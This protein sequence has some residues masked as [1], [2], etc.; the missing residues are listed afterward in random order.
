MKDVKYTG[1]TIH[2]TAKMAKALGVN[3]A[4]DLL[5][6]M[7]GDTVSLIPIKKNNKNTIKCGSGTYKLGLKNESDV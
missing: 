3:N 6:V 5:I 1:F 7:Y 2:I 4:E